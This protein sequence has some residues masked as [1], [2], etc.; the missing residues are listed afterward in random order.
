MKKIITGTLLVLFLSC[1]NAY[2]RGFIFTRSKKAPVPPPAQKVYTIDDYMKDMELEIKSNWVP[3]QN[4]FKNKTIV[5]FTILRDGT[6]QNPKISKSSGDKEFDRTAILALSAT[7]KVTP[8]PKNF[9]SDSI[10]IDFTFERFSYL[11]YKDRYDR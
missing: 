9:L 11:V 4:S 2:A 3:P 5:N 7:G 6:I 8:L 10:D 1:S